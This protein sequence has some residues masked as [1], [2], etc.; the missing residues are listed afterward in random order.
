MPL[1]N[2][3]MLICLVDIARLELSRACLQGLVSKPLSPA[4]VVRC[5]QLKD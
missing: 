4:C 5:L 3:C 1:V 2:I